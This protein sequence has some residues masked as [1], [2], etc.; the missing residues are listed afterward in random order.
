MITVHALSDTEARVVITAERVMPDDT[1]IAIEKHVHR[2]APYWYDEQGTGLGGY[3]RRGPALMA[4]TVLDLP[5]DRMIDER[6]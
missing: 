2:R 6:A 4:D 5:C 3:G 1:E